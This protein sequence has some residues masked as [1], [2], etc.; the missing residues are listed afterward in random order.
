MKRIGNIRM[1]NV[2]LRD[3]ERKDC[4]MKKSSIFAAVSRPR[5]QNI[6][7]GKEHFLCSFSCCILEKYKAVLNPLLATFHSNSSFLGRKLGGKTAFSIL[8]ILIFH[9]R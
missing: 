3:M 2:P 5:K 6:L 8:R 4:D 1:K 9:Q 7:I